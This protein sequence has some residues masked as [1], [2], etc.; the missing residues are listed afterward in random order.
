[1]EIDIVRC[2]IQANESQRQVKEPGCL[3]FSATFLFGV[4]LN[5]VADVDGHEI[6]DLGCRSACHGRKKK[7]KEVLL[8]LL[9]NARVAVE[10]TGNVVIDAVHLPTAIE[11]TVRDD[12]TGILSELL[13]RIFEPQFSTRSAGTGLGLAIVKK[14]INSWNGTVVAESG[15]GEGT[16]IRMQV[17]P[18]E[19][20]PESGETHDHVP[21]EFVVETGD[22]IAD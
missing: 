6:Y 20:S 2:L 13:G 10:G 11:V 17:R 12:G 3:Q 14:L 18:R 15:S 22:E 19:D 4:A 21:G 5:E 9:E 16:V 1:M 7:F 8:N